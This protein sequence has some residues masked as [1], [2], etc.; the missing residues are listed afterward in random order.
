MT[1]NI[2]FD[3]LLPIWLIAAL[4]GM[5]LCGVALALW[6]GLSGWTLRG[7]AGLVVLGTLAGPV[8]QQE[9]RQKLSDIVILVEDRSASQMLGDRSE[10]TS[11][12][13]DAIAAQLAA[14]DN[15]EVRRVTVPDGADNSGTQLMT[16]LS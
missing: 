10:T 9:D 2:V 15:T 11:R 16:A 5:V 6:R 7:L 12:A 4:A 3:P 14:R 13:A 8:Y 1:A